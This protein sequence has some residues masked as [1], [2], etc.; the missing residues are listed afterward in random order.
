RHGRGTRR[1]LLPHRPADSRRR[2]RDASGPEER[3]ASPRLPRQAAVR[4]RRARGRPA[5]PRPSRRRVAGGA[6]AGVEPA[7]RVRG[8][9]RVPADRCP[10]SAWAVMIQ[11]QME[12][13]A[14]DGIRRIADNIR[15]SKKVYIETVG[16]QMNVL[17]SELVV[18][19]LRRHGYSITHD[20]DDADL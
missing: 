3:D 4:S 16:C 11:S 7:S 19:S 15:M 20:W 12:K 2:P 9:T 1:R 10:D 17:D 5:P 18:G 14:L 13:P 8:G 6:R